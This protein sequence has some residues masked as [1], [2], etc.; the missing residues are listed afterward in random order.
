MTAVYG[1]G[2]Y[3]H[4]DVNIAVEEFILTDVYEYVV[5]EVM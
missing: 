3:S 4:W 5:A 2:K 1:R